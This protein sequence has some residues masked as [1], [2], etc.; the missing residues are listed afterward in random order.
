MWTQRHIIITH[1]H[2]SAPFFMRTSYFM[3]HACAYRAA[4]KAWETTG[5]PTYTM[6]QQIQNI[7][8]CR[9]EHEWIV[10][11][12]A[13]TIIMI[14]IVTLRATNKRHQVSGSATSSIP[15]RLYPV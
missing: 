2:I 13:T 12:C 6:L 5:S 10:T 15:S 3:R 14:I 8:E 4:T 11:L 1:H 7:C 9:Q